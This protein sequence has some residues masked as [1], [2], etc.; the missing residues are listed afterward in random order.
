M[1]KGIQKITNKKEEGDK[2]FL[3]KQ[4]EKPEQKFWTTTP[5]TIITNEKKNFLRKWKPAPSIPEQE[6]T[7]S[8]VRTLHPAKLYEGTKKEKPNDAKL[9]I[10]SIFK[11]SGGSYSKTVRV[12]DFNDRDSSLLSDRSYKPYMMLNGFKGNRTKGEWDLLYIS[13]LAITI[14]CTVWGHNSSSIEEKFSSDV[15]PPTYI[16]ERAEKVTLI[17][18]IEPAFIQGTKLLSFAKNIVKS[19]AGM[20]DPFAYTEPFCAEIPLPGCRETSEL[21]KFPVK[22]RCYSGV[23]YTL[24][25]MLDN[26]ILLPEKTLME[27][28]LPKEEKEKLEK[29]RLEK[30]EK[31]KNYITLPMHNRGVIEDLRTAQ[32]YYNKKKDYSHVKEINKAAAYY[33]SLIHKKDVKAALSDMILFD[34]AWRKPEKRSYLGFLTALS[35]TKLKGFTN[36]ALRKAAALGDSFK[37]FLTINGLAKDKSEYDHNRYM[38]SGKFKNRQKVTQKIK[39]LVLKLKSNGKKNTEVAEALKKKGFPLSVKSIERYI[40][41]LIKEGL[42]IPAIV[43]A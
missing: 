32:A 15:L 21:Q 19:Y 33:F 9:R 26:C 8:I 4:S 30:K 20:L 37:G 39:N 2:M 41:N 29:E 27:S 7:L 40:T 10:K 35:V 23:K 18:A 25:Q 38:E 34:N 24:Q 28:R 16:I 11:K 6:D 1:T 5:C 17:Y 14:G 22:W 31:Y 12:C 42:Y 36:K 3:K 43:A 13:A